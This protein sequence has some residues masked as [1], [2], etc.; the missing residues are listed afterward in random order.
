MSV[1]FHE[2][3]FRNRNNIPAELKVEAP[4]G[5]V[6]YGPQRWAPGRSSP[7]TWTDELQVGSPRVQHP[8]RTGPEQIRHEAG[9]LE[10]RFF[11]EGW[12][13]ILQLTRLRVS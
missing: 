2:V 7:S 3:V 1:R 8:P 5:N 9:E 12:E 4:I 11:E 13:A 10:M 6:V